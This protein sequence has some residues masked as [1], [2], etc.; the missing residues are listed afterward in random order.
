LN[1]QGLTTTEQAIFNQAAARWEQ[2]IVG[3]LPNAT[4]NGRVVDDLLIDASATTIDGVGGTLGQAGPDR[5]RIGTL[6]PYHGSMQFDTADLAS[7]QRD[8]SLLSVIE[9]EIG[10]ILGI[11]TLWDD[12]GLLTGAGTSNPRFTGA[13]ATAEY[14]TI[15]GVHETGVPVENTGGSGTRDAHW[16]ESVLSSEL[17]TG[18]AGPGTALPLSRI[19]VASLADIGY[20]VDMSK[21]DA[22]SRPGSS[23]ALQSTNSTSSSLSGV[24]AFESAIQRERRATDHIMT[25]W[26]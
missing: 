3:D 2:I 11:G 12:R 16:R 6:F 17:M 13:R 18:W 10:H 22:Y 19:T 23:S 21:A 4:Y 5:F 24:V 1:F 9:H 25:L 14:N 7:M 8:G 15:F 26:G 20:Q